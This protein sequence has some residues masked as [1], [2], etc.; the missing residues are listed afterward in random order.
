VFELAVRTKFS[1][2]HKL[3]RYKGSCSKLHGHTWTVEVSV[4]GNSLDD[5]GMLFDFIKLKDII[6]NIVKNF[7]HNYLNEVYPFTP[8]QGGEFLNPTTENIARFIF[9]ELKKKIGQENNKIT[10]QKVCVWESP[11]SAAAYSE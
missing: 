6:N 7:D 9:F 2:A 10:V 5:A 11:N 3:L 1:A 8:R 4:A